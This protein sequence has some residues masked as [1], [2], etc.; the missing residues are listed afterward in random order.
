MFLYPRRQNQLAGRALSSAA[1]FFFFAACPL[2]AQF[3]AAIQGTVSDESGATVPAAKVSLLNE[4][5]Q[6]T[7]ETT[8]SGSGFYYFG[9]LAPGNYTVSVELTGFQKAVKEHV[10]TTAEQTIGVNLKLVP[11]EVSQTVTVS[12]NTTPVLE[13][14]NAS[15]DGTISSQ[16]INRLPQVGRDPYETVRFTPGVFG[17]GARSGGGGS[18]SVPNTNSVGGSSQSVFATE[19]VVPVSG[20]GQRTSANTYEIDGVSVNSQTWGGGAVITP[21]QEFVKDIRVS[22]SS[23]SAESRAGGVNVQTVSKNGTNEFH[24]S[25]FYK[26]D[27]PSLNAYARWAGPFGGLPQKNQNIFR[28]FGG[29]LGGPIIKNHLFAFFTYETLRQANGNLS[30][31]FLET[32]SYIADVQSLRPNSIAAT[33]TGLAGNSPQIA[34]ILT[35]NCGQL[36]LNGANQCAVVSGGLDIGSIGG[37]R[38]QPV[39]NS[40]GGGLDGR[41]DLQ[42]VQAR[43]FGNQTASQYDGRVDWQASQRDRIFF[44]EFYI[45]FTNNFPNSANLR[46][47]VFWNS[48]R[49]SLMGALVWTHTLSNTMVNEAR[50]NVLRWKFDELASNPNIPWGIPPATV[51]YGNTP[52][53]WGAPGPGIFGQTTY[54][55]RD[56]LIKVAGSHSISLGL[57]IAKEQNNDVVGWSARPQFDFGNIWNFANDAPIDESGGGFDPRT[58]LPTSLRKYIRTFTYS[59][60]VQDDWKVRPNLTLNLGLRWDYYTPI[61][62]KF[63]NISNVILGGGATTLT[64][65]RIVTGGQQWRPNKNNWG[66]QFGF[67]YSPTQRTVVRGGFGIGYNRVPQSLLL[68]GRLNPPLYNSPFVPGNLARPFYSL[69]AGPIN[70]FNGFPA[71]PSTRLNFDPNTGFPIGGQLT[72]SP[73]LFIVPQYFPQPMIYRYSLGMQ[74]DLG[75]NWAA[76][77]GYQGSS[78]RHF[79]RATQYGLIYPDNP[80]A[81][82]FQVVNNDVNTSFNALLAHVEK[83]FSSGFLVQ[84]QYRWSKAIDGGCSTD[85]ICTQLWQFDR[86]LQRSVSDFDVKHYF[87]ANALWNIPV[88]RDRSKWTGRLLGGWELNGVITASSGYPWSP[89]YRDNSCDQISGQGGLCPALPVSWDG[90]GGDDTTNST[91]QQKN[92]SFPGG[93]APHFVFP[94]Y[95]GGLVPSR[96]GVGRNIFRGP[97]Y[98]QIDM[99]GSK[100]FTLPPLPFFGENA[101]LDLRANAFNIFNKLNLTPFTIGSPTV[102]INNSQFGQAGSALVGR[103]VELQARFSF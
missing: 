45:P 48:D 57:D 99:S 60:F 97:N 55:Y 6:A 59:G 34:S 47:N 44:S 2:F 9:R 14:E 27:S 7:Q 62:E 22:S 40:F 8:S 24:G 102:Q 16:Q 67:A 3:R 68:N 23:Y 73:N 33:V 50:F 94:T 25:A 92:G 36:D 78:G 12:G 1:F 43:T 101:S 70:S 77:L 17:L 83:R 89:V 69:A 52:I 37:L 93:A 80:A 56:T 65:A 95:N 82:Y 87:V 39:A 100:R 63:G 96:P 49:L 38:G 32:P 26:Y 30:N 29:S 11:G 76:S 28:Q 61:T 71:I 13:T 64:D 88:F 18:V 19:N 81:N 86:N 41:A 74:F 66:P 79:T 54:D 91:F 90:I 58:G 72:S 4:D 75:H 84:A 21:S 46:Q 20:N 31:V 85:Q 51:N 35:P 5:T 15:I 53:R 98:F 42:Y 10:A 103:T